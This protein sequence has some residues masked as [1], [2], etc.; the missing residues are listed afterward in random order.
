[1]SSSSSSSK[2]IKIV[3]WNVNGIRAL[4]K[5]K[6]NTLSALFER[7]NADIVCFQ[8]TKINEA[9]LKR[10]AHVRHVDGYE[11]FFASHEHKAGYCGVA[12]YCKIGMTRR[13][14]IGWGSEQQCFADRG[15][16]LL[17]DHGAFLL[18]NL[19]VVNGAKDS[20]QAE[21]KVRF[22]RELVAF[23]RRCER[24]LVVVGDMNAAHRLVD[25]PLESAPADDA[26][27][28]GGFKPFE[29]QFIADMIG[30]GRLV[31]SFRA[32]R[33]RERRYT[34]FDTRTDARTDNIGYRIDYMFVSTALAEQNLIVDADVLSDQ[35]G[36]DHVPTTLELIAP[37][38][39]ACDEPAPEHSSRKLLEAQPSI[40]Q[41]FS[42]KTKTRAWDDDGDDDKEPAPAKR[43]RTRELKI[44]SFF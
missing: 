43:Q 19:Y 20:E 13:C 38:G 24:P 8:E 16:A 3:S 22:I 36:S 15:R 40:T 11:S 44:T 29:R 33:P 14:Q 5:D 35:M 23:C 27:A 26:N 18:L 6:S 31:D 37:D 42:S 21:F 17:T 32:F 4:V 30:H 1:M 10:A 7:W 2:V 34:W 25:T 41:F 39:L 12:T 28:P 9:A